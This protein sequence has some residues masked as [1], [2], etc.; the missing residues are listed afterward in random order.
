MPSGAGGQTGKT[1]TLP[2]EIGIAPIGDYFTG[3][4]NLN[5]FLASA[6]FLLLVPGPAVLYIGA[7][8]LDKG[9]LAGVAS[10]LGIE[11][12]NFVHL[13]A[14]T[15][16]LSA[17]LVSSAVLFSV[18][19]NGRRV[20]RVFGGAKNSNAR[21]RLPAGRHGRTEPGGHISPGRGGGGIKPED[22][23]FLSGFPAAICGCLQGPGFGV[24]VCSRMPIRPD[25]GMDRRGVCAD[26]GI[27]GRVA[28]T[29]ALFFVNRTLPHRGSLYRF[30]NNR[31]MGGHP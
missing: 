24:M 20:L 5:L 9:R 31:R 11:A 26:G 16:G 17:L 18:V 19:K 6:L 14:V 22:R 30:G 3:I 13:Q 2:L 27:G 8:S 4:P 15:L 1:K 10:V 28:E 29:N 25:G 21:V 7:R 23:D 12:G